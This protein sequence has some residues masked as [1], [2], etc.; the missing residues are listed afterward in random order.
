[1][2]TNYPT[3]DPLEYLLKMYPP[4]FTKI[5]KRIYGNVYFAIM[6]H[7]GN[8]GVC[9]TLGNPIEPVEINSPI[10][11]ESPSWRI[12]LI[13][14]YNALLNPHIKP[15]GFT[16]IFNHV[17]F[18]S[19][20]NIVMIGF[21]R[22]LVAKFDSHGIPVKVFD[23]QQEDTRLTPYEQLD[24]ELQRADN[25]IIT[26]TTFVNNT[27]ASIISKIRPDA[28]AYLLGPSSIVH[29]VIF[30]YPQVLA[31]F[32]M[33]FQANRKMVLDIIANNGGT[34]DFSSFAQKTLLLRHTDHT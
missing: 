18:N 6:L 15:N 25:V 23:I 33:R 16:D 21:F 31:I 28:K 30:N 13:A 32:G 12:L 10:A 22:P 29:P 9:A 5:A 1:M 14:F 34:P 2:P 19:N 3:P 20:D 7:D 4:D 17:N 26:S 11:L 8:I 27:F 24:S